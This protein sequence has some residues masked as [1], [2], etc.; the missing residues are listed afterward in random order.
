MAAVVVLTLSGATINTMV[1][2]GLVIALGEVVDD[3]II[4]VENI[5][6][7]LRLARATGSTE[8]PFQIVL[9]ASLEVRSAVVYASLIVMLVFVPVFFLDGIAG[10][11]FR[12]LALAYILAILASLLV[13]LIVTP[14]L[15]LILLTG[16]ASHRSEL[17]ISRG[18]RRMYGALLPKFVGRP[19][20]SVIVLLAAFLLAGA[21]TTRLGR[22]FLPEFQETDFLMH[23]LERPG[24]SIEAMDRM[25]VLA[26][27]ELRA[28]P[29]V[30]NFGSH[31]GRAEVADEVYGPNFTE[32]WISI[33]DTVDYASTVA[34]I[35][36]AMDGYP[37]MSCD[38]Q[39]Y[40]KEPQQRGALRCQARAS[41]CGCSA[42]TWPACD[43]RPKRSKRS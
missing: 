3:A 30:R 6:R 11:F 20:M 12:P 14:A 13:A 36:A 34:R 10:S 27:R 8:S 43:R 16:R 29:G 39:T 25:T 17:P 4:D 32:L 24:T 33:D 37:G 15:S 22:E 2:A 23:F 28:I 9:A 38:V 42:P 18:L 26:S 31:I 1:L 21:A 41:S 19:G 40:L 7:R 35:Q 5:V